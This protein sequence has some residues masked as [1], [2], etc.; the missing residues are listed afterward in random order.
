MF[1]RNNIF[2]RSY[3]KE[4]YRAALPV[5]RMV[6]NLQLSFHMANILQG[7]AQSIELFARRMTSLWAQGK[8]GSFCIS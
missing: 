5:P 7:D 1:G 2:F 3:Y 6:D 8:E 4:K